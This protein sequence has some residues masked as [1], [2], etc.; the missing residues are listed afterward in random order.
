MCVC[1]CVCVLDSNKI[2]MCLSVQITFF[3][4]MKMSNSLNVSTLYLKLFV[5]SDDNIIVIDNLSPLHEYIL[6]LLK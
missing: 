5:I 1:V 2:T 4:Q 6:F 3:I